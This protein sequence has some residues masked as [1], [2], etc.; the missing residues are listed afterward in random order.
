MEH[1]CDTTVLGQVQSVC[2]IN[3]MLNFKFM[4]ILEFCAYSA[5]GSATI[6]DNIFC[7]IEG[8]GELRQS[9]DT[10]EK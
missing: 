3:V 1:W 7:Y 9:D 10:F 2:D 4:C 8:S 6:A 5:H